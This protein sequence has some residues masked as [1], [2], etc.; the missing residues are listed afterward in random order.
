MKNENFNDIEYIICQMNNLTNN[1]FP[2]KYNCFLEL[3]DYIIE[4]YK[5]LLSIVDESTSQNEMINKNNE[6]N[7]NI[8]FLNCLLKQVENSEISLDDFFKKANKIRNISRLTINGHQEKIFNKTIKLS[9]LQE[10]LT[11]CMCKIKKS[12]SICYLLLYD[13]KNNVKLKKNI[14]NIFKKRCS[15]NYNIICFEQMLN[16]Y[17]LYR[18]TRN[19]FALNLAEEIIKE[20]DNR[21]YLFDDDKIN[22]EIE[23]FETLFEKE[24]I[25]MASICQQLIISLK[26]ETNIDN[27]IETMS[28]R[29]YLLSKLLLQEDFSNEE[30][31]T[32]LDTVNND[33]E[34]N[35]I[36]FL[37][38]LKLLRP[39]LFEMINNT[40][41]TIVPE[42][43]KKLFLFF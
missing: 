22:N 8:L 42:K 37:N 15:K 26:N 43:K 13:L 16:N 33:F 4:Y 2:E 17:I 19:I 24:T 7:K 32:M 10:Q 21:Q 27:Y 41:T 11:S 40:K 31:K 25:D 1:I 3:E 28:N 5:I 34:F 23:K 9:Q 30:I 20:Y 12:Y 38:N 18:K 29:L 6:N 14:S 35:K 39:D 36:V